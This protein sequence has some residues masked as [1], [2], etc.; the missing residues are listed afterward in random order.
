MLLIDSQTLTYADVC[1]RMQ[2]LL[3][4]AHVR[5]LLI[6]LQTPEYNSGAAY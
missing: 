3:D 5:M 6:D 2:V 4:K 1:S